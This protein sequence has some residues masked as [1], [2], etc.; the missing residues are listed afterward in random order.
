MSYFG[1]ATE[2]PSSGAPPDLLS[3]AYPRAYW[4]AV[5]P[6]ARAN[7][8]DPRLLLALARKESLFDASV[9]SNAGAIGLFQLMLET[10]NRHKAAAGLSKVTEGDLLDPA[11]SA[12]IAAR[13][14]R[15]LM[16]RYNGALPA[17]VAA[18]NAGHER[19]D[20]WWTS[21]RALP[22]DLF[23]DTIPYSETRR[24]VRE[25]LNN[26]RMYQLIDGQRSRGL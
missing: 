8:I 24:Y 14:I 11:V 9:R 21:G 26:Y 2:R 6:A 5:E 20:L 10:A 7:D 4:N 22:E 17:V 13:L 1:P 15:T 19:V 3:L 18:Y 16:E 12:A 25:V 23:I